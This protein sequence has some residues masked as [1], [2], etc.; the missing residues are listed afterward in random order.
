MADN[1]ITNRIAKL[2]AMVECIMKIIRDLA[3]LFCQH[4]LQ[5]QELNKLV[6]QYKTTISK[7][8]A[9]RLSLK[10]Q[11]LVGHP[12]PNIEMIVL[13]PEGVKQELS[14]YKL[15]YGLLDSKYYYC[16]A[17]DWAEVFSWIYLEFDM[18]SYLAQRFDC[19]D[20]ALLL[21]GLVASFF[22][23][24]YFGVAIGKKG[25]VSHAFNFFR[26]ERGL[27]FLEPQSGEFFSPNEKDYTMGYVLL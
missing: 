1:N 15:L 12:K 7:C 17:E 22:G 13:L 23:L 11:T 5:I 24:N 8:E 9:E 3:R 25:E 26:T 16:R 20:S 14:E 19:E 27:L 2:L 18:P 21:K 10:S 6:A 4:Q